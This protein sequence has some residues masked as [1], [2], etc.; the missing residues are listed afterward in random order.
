[1][2]I[3]G[4]DNE[5]HLD[6]WVDLLEKHID[7]PN[8]K[9]AGIEKEPLQ[10]V[11]MDTKF[12]ADPRTQVFC[13][14]AISGKNFISCLRNID[15][16][17]EDKVEKL[18]KIAGNIPNDYEP[19]KI[20]LTWFFDNIRDDQVLHQMLSARAGI[21][22]SIFESRIDC[23]CRSISDCMNRNISYINRF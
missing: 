21:F 20:K 3:H 17:I 4:L 6:V 11:L 18:K 16:H 23:V 13:R 10:W 7:N 5:E 12:L 15:T 14:V 8:V 2:A 19:M 9:L 22:W 1:M